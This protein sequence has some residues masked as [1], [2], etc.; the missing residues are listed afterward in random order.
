MGMPTLPPRSNRSSRPPLTG[1]GKEAGIAVG[2]APKP[3][4]I[5]GSESNRLHQNIQCH[6]LQSNPRETNSDEITYSRTSSKVAA[7]LSG[8]RTE[9]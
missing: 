2:G 9:I 8:R 3:A 7:K 5:C 6:I 1:G 4:P